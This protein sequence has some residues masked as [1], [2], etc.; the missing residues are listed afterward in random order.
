MTR[1]TASTLVALLLSGLAHAADK[2]VLDNPRGGWR[3]SAS[4]EKDFLQEVH[5]PAANVNTEGLKSSALIA[6]R[7]RADIAAAPKTGREPARLVVY[8]HRPINVPVNF[9]LENVPLPPAAA[10]GGPQP[11]PG[12]V[13]RLRVKLLLALELDEAHRWPACRLGVSIVVLLRLDI[14][15]HVFWRHQAH[16]VTLGFQEPAEVM[17]ATARLHRHDTGRHRFGEGGDVLRPDT[18]PLD[19]S[20]G[21]I[22]C[23]KLQLFLPKSI[24]LARRAIFAKVFVTCQKARSSD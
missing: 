19:H 5:Y 17:R 2:P 6:G 4:S 18:P 7:I 20:A 23:H 21:L 10:P 12:T 22:K 15:A 9:R 16:R 3:A 11:L 24:G 13:Q 8:G 1:F 14:G